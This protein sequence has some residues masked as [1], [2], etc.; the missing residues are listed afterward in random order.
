MWRVDHTN[1]WIEDRH[2]Y[3]AKRKIVDYFN[4]NFYLASGKFRTQ[5]LNRTGGTQRRASCLI[6]LA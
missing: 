3:P 5:T 4:A 6:A 2:S 1:G